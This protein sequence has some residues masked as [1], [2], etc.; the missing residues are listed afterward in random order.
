MKTLIGR[1]THGL[2]LV[3][4][5]LTLAAEAARAWW[6]LE[7]IV[8]FRPHLLAASA[9]I[10]LVAALTRRKAVAALAFSAL[11]GNAIPL[12]GLVWGAPSIVAGPPVLKLLTANVL[13][14]H[15]EPKRL[16]AWITEQDPDVILLL[17]TDKRWDAALDAPLKAWR[18]RVMGS[19]PDNFGMSLYSRLPLRDGEVIQ[20]AGA[21]P[22]VRA[23]LKVGGEVLQI[24]GIHAPPPIGGDMAR[25][26]AAV[27]AALEPVLATAPR[28]ILAGDFNNT[29]WSPS[30]VD[31]LGALRMTRASEGPGLYATWPSP[32]G[33]VGLPID[34]VLYRGLSGVVRH[35]IGPAF[36]SDHRPLITEFGP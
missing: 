15:G 9:L 33:G 36:G 22:A 23:R 4:F 11:V 31:L 25:E 2:L 17:E 19:R 24:V 13:T 10:L 29:A 3:I 26:R 32:L 30:F 21:V 7:L 27:Y 16:L 14:G 5:P 18:H 12:R 6:P 28:A 20:L 35:Q 34:H 1:L 8:H